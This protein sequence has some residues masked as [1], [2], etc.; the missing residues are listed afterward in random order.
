MELLRKLEEMKT[1]FETSDGLSSSDKTF[2]ENYYERILSKSFNNRGCGQCY[3]DAFIEMYLYAKKNGIKE[4]GKFVMKREVVRTIGGT[5]YSRNNITDDKAIE[6]LKAYP[7]RIEDFE[8]Y[9]DNWENLL[10]TQP[11]TKRAKV[12]QPKD[13]TNDQPTDQ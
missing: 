7:Q 9:P 2:I 13:A 6:L 4:M 11:K 5:V 3:R 12:A 10:S 1:R 8:V